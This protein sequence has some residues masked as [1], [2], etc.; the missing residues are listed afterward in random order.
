MIVEILKQEMS[1]ST[2]TREGKPPA[3][4]N[5]QSSQLHLREDHH[6]NTDIVTLREIADM[7]DDL[8][9]PWLDL[10]ETAFPRKRRCW[11]RFSCAC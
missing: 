4:E 9:L 3:G 6:L 8:L 11:C 2:V 5:M 10:F 1:Y 7:N